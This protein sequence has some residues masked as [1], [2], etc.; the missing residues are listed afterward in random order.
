MEEIFNGVDPLVH[1]SRI[2]VPYSWWAGDTAS[3]F[4]VALRDEKKIMGT[5]CAACN[6]TFVPPRK[7]CPSCFG[8]N[9]E[10]V[11]VAPT[12]TLES[13]TVVRRQLAAL[14]KKVPVAFGLIRLDGADTSLLHYLDEVAPEDI[15]IGRRFKACFASDPQGNILDITHFKPI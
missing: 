13:F 15:A 12:G 5:R 8:K 10:W 4:L 14:P 9:T 11:E 6:R 1:Q 2:N 7:T 3:R